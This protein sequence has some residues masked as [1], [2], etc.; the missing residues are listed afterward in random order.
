MNPLR[1]HFLGSR[2][3]GA[4]HCRQVHERAQ[5]ARLG[6]STTLVLRETPW[7]FS[8]ISGCNDLAQSVTR[9][10]A[11]IGGREMAGAFP[12]FPDKTQPSLKRH[13]NIRLFALRL[14]ENTVVNLGCLHSQYPSSVDNIS[15]CSFRPN[16][17]QYQT[18]CC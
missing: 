2:R 4:Y 18:F 5:R 9:E 3:R 6:A 13:A 7:Y 14:Q 11:D 16:Y 8:L 1:R 15:I 12:R 17:M 10:G